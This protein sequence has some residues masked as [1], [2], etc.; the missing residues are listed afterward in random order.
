MKQSLYKTGGDVFKSH[1]QYK[2]TY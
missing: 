2:H 1:G